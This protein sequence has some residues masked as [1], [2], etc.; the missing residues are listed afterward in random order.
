MRARPR[1]GFSM[2]STLV[3]DA[4]YQVSFPWMQGSL[5]LAVRLAAYGRGY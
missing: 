4:G 1:A 2:A 3:N 5:L